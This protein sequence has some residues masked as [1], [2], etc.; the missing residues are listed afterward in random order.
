MTGSASIGTVLASLAFALFLNGTAL[1]GDYFH[2][3]ADASGDLIITDGV[4]RQPRAGTEPAQ[5]PEIKFRETRRITIH[6][7][8][9]QCFSNSCG[10]SFDYELE[11]YLLF[12]DFE[13]DGIFYQATFVCERVINALPAACECDDES[14]AY[15]RD[16]KPEF[17]EKGKAR[18]AR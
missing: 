14:I 1:A 4:L 11:S 10:R 5:R 2:S 13:Y 17:T 3:C 8:E 9:G 16:L 6:R 15:Q 18:K 7:K 12:A